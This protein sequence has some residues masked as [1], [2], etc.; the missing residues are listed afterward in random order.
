MSVRAVLKA[1]LNSPTRRMNQPGY[2]TQIKH[3]QPTI[4]V[5]AVLEI[6]GYNCSLPVLSELPLLAA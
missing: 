6:S 1:S 5:R 2:N 3:T 4:S